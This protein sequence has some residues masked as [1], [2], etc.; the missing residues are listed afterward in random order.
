MRWLKNIW[1]ALRI[2]PEVWLTYRLVQ[3]S[4]RSHHS[5][6]KQP[7]LKGSLLRL[8]SFLWS[9]ITTT[10]HLRSTRVDSKVDL[11]V[12]VQSKNQGEALSGTVRSLCPREVPLCVIASPKAKAGFLSHGYHEYDWKNWEILDSLKLVFLSVVRAPII[13]INLSKK[14]ARLRSWYFEKLLRCHA[15]LIYFEKAL[16]HLK[17]K[18][19]LI[20]ND[21][22]PA[23]RC[24]I[25]LARAKKIKIAYIQHASVSTLFPALTFDYC[26]LDGSIAVEKYLECEKNK[27]KSSMMPSRRNIF[28]TGQKKSVGLAVPSSTKTVGLATNSLDHIDDVEKLVSDP[29]LAGEKVCIR[30]HP[31]TNLDVVNK[32]KEISASDSLVMISDPTKESLCE[33]LSKIDVLIAGNSSIHLEAAIAGVVPIYYEITPPE[34]PDY[35]GYVLNGVSADARP[36]NGLKEVIAIIREGGWKPLPSAIQAYSATFFTCWQDREGELAADILKRL[37]RGIDVAECPTYIGYLDWQGKAFFSIN[38]NDDSD[39]V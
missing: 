1:R 35:Y 4:D 21:H 15:Y 14:R 36:T 38:D 32:L 22:N 9:F 20:S 16:R 17:P 31:V 23:N 39:E 2:M 25:A 5:S 27:P 3:L 33:F 13:W 12:F 18:I 24:L 28:L 11:L 19:I 6:G 7:R 8:V 29:Q 10:Q 30:W 34:W 37:L 26:L